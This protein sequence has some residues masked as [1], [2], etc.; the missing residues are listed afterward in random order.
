[1]WPRSSLPVPSVVLDSACIWR[2]PAE[3]GQ[4]RAG[5]YGRHRSRERGLKLNL[6]FFG[7]LRQSDVQS[8]VGAGCKVAAE[9]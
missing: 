1:V 6:E 3:V 5:N 8:R 9:V 7:L 4:D 2:L